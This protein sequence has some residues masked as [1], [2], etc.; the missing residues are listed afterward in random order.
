MLVV[1]LI[2]AGSAWSA[3]APRLG[4]R[5]LAGEAARAVPGIRVRLAAATAG[6]VADGQHLE[7]SGKGFSPHAA[8]VVAQCSAQALAEALKSIS[9]AL[10]YCDRRFVAVSATGASGAFSVR[11][12]VLARIQTASGPI[13]CRMG[14]CLLGALNLGVLHGAPLQVAVTTLAFRGSVRRPSKLRSRARQLHLLERR[15]L[16]IAGPGRP[17]RLRLQALPAATLGA[18]RIGQ[19]VRIPAGA[20]PRRP[21]LGEGLLALTMSAPRTSWSDPR[22]T[23]VVVQARVDRGRWQAIVLFA[24]GHPFTYEGFTGPLSSGR[25]EVEV[26]VRGDLSQVADH[27]PITV[28]HRAALRVVSATAPGGLA[29]QYAPV[30]YDR[31]IS[32]TGD[33][34]LITY[35]NE[36]PLRH[37]SRRL[38]YVVTWTHEDAGTGFVPWLEWGT[39]GRMT[40]VES[41]IA[42]TVDHAGRVSDSS[43]LTC[44]LCGPRFPENRTALDETATP[45]HGAWYFHHPVLR[46][47]TGNNDFSDHGATQIRFQPALSAPPA[48]SETREGAMDRNPWTYGLM[49]A[50][51][52]RERD[53]FSENP[54]SAA[55]G[56]PAQYLIVDLNTT[57]VH[58]AAVGV[59]IRLAGDKTVYSND[60]G[61]TYPLYDGGQGRTTVKVPLGLVSRP[62]TMLRL[63]LLASGS[64]IPSISIH[65]ARVLQYKR[66]RIVRRRLPALRVLLEPAPPAPPAGAPGPTLSLSATSH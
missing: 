3:A 17:A 4:R 63:R 64:A 62:I 48:P 24:G 56:T 57:A 30:L 10:D 52:R 37:G 27:A 12:R 34:P 42:F 15:P 5:S 44:T 2:G 54:A 22:D 43:Y 1:G 6:T 23:S 28:I 40:D 8:V 53:D 11:S 36:Q 26:R 45:F 49:G 35:A 13:D 20:R 19:V 16:G 38:S 58:A 41:A 39:W 59:D 21:I 18:G 46:V 61:T 65:R 50:E 55:P 32:T 47:A 60:L 66:G 51:L 31:R 25:H 9:G 7:V 33:T 14:S 29:L